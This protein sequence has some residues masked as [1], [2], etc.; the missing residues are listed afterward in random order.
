MKKI[1]LSKNAHDVA[2]SRYYMNG[3]EW[4]DCALRVATT[5]STPEFNGFSTRRKNP[6]E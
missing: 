4:E 1:E 3:E 6:K 2:K 5:I